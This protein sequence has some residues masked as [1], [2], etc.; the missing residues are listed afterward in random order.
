MHALVEVLLLYPLSLADVLLLCLCLSS[1][2]DRKY[3]KWLCQ[4]FLML[5]IQSHC[6][7]DINH[8]HVKLLV[9]GPMDAITITILT[10][11]DLTR[12]SDQGW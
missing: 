8:M 3:L 9:M 7:H 1:T 11:R 6:L 10:A 2:E 12:F 5:V 4:F